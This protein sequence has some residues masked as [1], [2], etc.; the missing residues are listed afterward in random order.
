MSAVHADPPDRG[1]LGARLVVGHYPAVEVEPAVKGPHGKVAQRCRL[2]RRGPDSEP[3]DDR[4]HGRIRRA[5]RVCGARSPASAGMLELPVPQARARWSRIHRLEA[6]VRSRA[7][8]PA[9]G[10]ACRT[11]PPARAP[12]PS[13]SLGESAAGGTG[14]PPRTRCSAVADSAWP[15]ARLGPLRFGRAAAM[16]S[17]ARGARADDRQGRLPEHPQQDGVERGLIVVEVAVALGIGPQVL[18][19]AAGGDHDPTAARV[20]HLPQAPS[21]TGDRPVEGRLEPDQRDHAGRRSGPD[22]RPRATRY[23][24]D[25]W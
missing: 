18:R 17:A 1:E 25:L 3:L 21:V 10:W 11:V 4:R 8:G 22:S 14:S 24:R 15:A 13:G 5:C 7:R 9:P 2:G 19:I 12:R 6:V 23:S 20:D 16:S